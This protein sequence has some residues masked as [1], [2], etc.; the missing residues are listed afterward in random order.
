M[1]TQ[2]IDRTDEKYILAKELGLNGYRIRVENEKLVKEFT[3]LKFK[4]ITRRQIEKALRKLYFEVS[5]EAFMSALF[6]GMIG[7]TISIIPVSEVSPLFILLAPLSAVLGFFGRAFQLAEVDSMP[8]RQWQDNLPY[9]ALLATKEAKEAGLGSF[10]IFYPV[11]DSARRLLSDP[12]ITGSKNGID[13]E[14]FNWDDGKIY[15]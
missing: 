13:F 12:I 5:G 9:G 6:I 4:P 2:V 3:N 7:A 1:N 15:E 8:L 11:K 14:V 10:Q